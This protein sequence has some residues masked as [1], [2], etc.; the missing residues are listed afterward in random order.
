MSGQ[1]NVLVVDDEPGMREFL[2]IMLGK[3]GYS[4][5]IASNGE[6]AIQKIQNEAFD[7]ALVDIQMPGLNGIDVLRSAKETT[8]DTTI[9]MI[10]AFASHE[11]AIE[12][13]K[14]GAYDYITKPFKIDEIKLVISKS[15]ERKNLVTENTRLKKELENKYGFQNIIGSSVSIKQIFSLINRVSE[16]KVSVLITGESGTGKELVARAIHYSGN[17]KEGP[18]IPVNCAAIPETLIES[19]FFGHS[20]GAFTGATRDTKGLFEEADGG[21]IFLDEI[22]DLPQHLQVKLLRVLEEK[23]VRPLGKTE[24]VNI[25]VRVISAT[26]RKLEQEIAEGKFREDLFY[27]L[28]VIKIEIPPL[29]ERKEDIPPIAIHF[30]EKYADE[31]EKNI[32]SIS[33]EALEELEK[34]SFP[35][36]VRELENI[37]ARCVALETSEVIR[38]ES[39]P[40]LTTD[41]DYID[42]SDT[43]NAYDSIDSVLGDVEKQIIE[44]A[45][46]TTRGNKTEAAERLGITLRSLRYRLAKHRIYDEQL[47]REPI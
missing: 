7:L 29:R 42:L 34:Y 31:M 36:N 2:E 18:F 3:E 10:T 28:N 8:P 25:D 35:G 9:I 30:V 12:A 43:I 40:K 15:L 1:H 47:N 46:K 6:E 17:R 23:K 11:T 26:N 4:V 41:N 13:M 20:K 21:T 22:G 19:E 39:L 16:L 45:L 44:N 32:K 14:L 33:S 24:P 38:K 27:R 5:K 37:I